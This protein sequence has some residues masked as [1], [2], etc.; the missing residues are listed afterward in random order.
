MA[1]EASKPTLGDI[2]LLASPR[3]LKPTQTMLLTGDQTFRHLTISGDISWKPP[4][5]AKQISSVVVEYIVT[6]L[7]LVTTQSETQCYDTEPKT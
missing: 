2:F 7:F 3:L 5:V 4:N 6:W 1:F